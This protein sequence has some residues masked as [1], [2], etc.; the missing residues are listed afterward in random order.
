MS[1]VDVCSASHTSLLVGS[2]YVSHTVVV[3][4]VLLFVAVVVVVAT[5]FSVV[6]L[7]RLCSH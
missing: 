1:V 2:C 5:V 3:V 6:C 4:V 7:V